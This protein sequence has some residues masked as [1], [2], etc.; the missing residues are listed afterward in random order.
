MVQ[1]LVD[2]LC[3][4]AQFSDDK[5]RDWLFTDQNNSF[6]FKEGEAGLAG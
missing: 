3:V 1:A 4:E 6:F 5:R 2:V